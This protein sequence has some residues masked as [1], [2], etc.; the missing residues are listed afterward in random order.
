V[1][2]RA[3]RLLRKEG[4]LRGRGRVG[5]ASILKEVDVCASDASEAVCDAAPLA[6]FGRSIPLMVARSGVPAPLSTFANADTCG[7]GSPSLAEM[8]LIAPL[9]V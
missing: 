2:G 6:A 5:G 1:Q 8:Q 9:S 7:S 3:I 4:W